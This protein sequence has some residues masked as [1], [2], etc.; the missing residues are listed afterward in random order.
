[1]SGST[2]SRAVAELRCSTAG[3]E[4]RDFVAVVDV[5]VGVDE[6]GSPPLRAPDRAPFALAPDKLCRHRTMIARAQS[7]S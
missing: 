6:V 1:M 4:E 7:H 2:G 3:A 5:D